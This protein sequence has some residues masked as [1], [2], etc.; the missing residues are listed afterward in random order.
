MKKT[1]LLFTIFIFFWSCIFKLE[2]EN[3]KAG[4]SYLVVSSNFTDV[5]GEQE[6]NL[7]YSSNKTSDDGQVN[8]VNFAEVSI[9]DDQNNIINFQQSGSGRY[10]SSIPGIPGRK[11]TLKL[12]LSNGKKYH[13]LPETMPLC[14]DIQ[15]LYYKFEM[16]NSQTDYKRKYGYNLYVDF[17]DS[18][19]AGEFY[20][21][22][23]IHYELLEICATCNQTYRVDTIRQ[24]CRKISVTPN[25]DN[26]NLDGL[27][28]FPCFQHCW[29]ITKS[30]AFNLFSDN[31]YNGKFINGI[32]VHRALFKYVQ[33]EYYLKIQ[34]RKINKST[35]LYLRSVETQ[36]KSNGTLFDVPAQTQFNFNLFSDDDPQE[37]ILGNFNVYSYKTKIIS[38][39]IN[40]PVAGNYP[41]PVDPY[42]S[43]Y[44]EA[45]PSQLSTIY[46]NCGNASNRSNIQPE[47]WKY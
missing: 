28:Y 24:S 12:I 43:P 13:S 45:A 46:A 14:P 31:Y 4:N 9:S 42:K 5:A 23:W 32:K 3:H 38:I 30:D 15:N 16:D 39:P 40:N 44:M 20:Q 27:N 6:I 25:N 7:H 11:Y 8:A 37:K 2:N 21:W 35:Y 34:Q 1:I 18:P 41:A 26:V 22:N 33:S 47:G 10:V 17:Q 36:V 19:I 29:E